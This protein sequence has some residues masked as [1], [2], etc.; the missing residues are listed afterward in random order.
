LQLETNAHAYAWF[1]FIKFEYSVK[2]IDDLWYTTE[3]DNIFKMP[4]CEAMDD[5]EVEEKAR[6][7][8]SADK[9]ML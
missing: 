1:L 7:L 3:L 6:A 4:E 2:I 9:I 5:D 8:F